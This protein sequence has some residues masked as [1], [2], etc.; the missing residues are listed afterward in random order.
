M[1]PTR[2]TPE[3][4][5]AVRTRNGARPTPRS[6]CFR[7]SFRQSRISNG[8]VYDVASETTEWSHDFEAGRLINPGQ[9]EEEFQVLL[10]NR[11]LVLISHVALNSDAAKRP[12][13]R[14]V[15]AEHGACP[16]S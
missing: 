9:S 10:S 11:Q 16:P 3:R 5:F 7:V 2:G 4:S 12:S 6:P 1:L 15:L 8:R 14:Q 13:P